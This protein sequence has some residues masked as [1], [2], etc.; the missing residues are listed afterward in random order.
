[1]R[2][3]LGVASLE[4]SRRILL[5][6]AAV[7]VG[8]MPFFVSPFLKLPPV[9]I[10]GM[11]LITA[12]ILVVVA[13]AILGAA[14][15]GGDLGAGRLSFFFSRPLSGASVFTG[16]VLAAILL[17]LLSGLLAAIPVLSMASGP[18]RPTQLLSVSALHVG[19]VLLVL[20]AAHFLG[21]V[22]RARSPWLVLDVAMLTLSAWTL[23]EL[24]HRLNAIGAMLPGDESQKLTA[25]VWA[26][27]SAFFA[28]GLV[29]VVV[30]RTDLARGH[31][32]ASLT[33]WPLFLV[34]PVGLALRLWW[35]E[36]A[37]PRDLTQV[38][39][40]RP[41]PA[42]EWFFLAGPARGGAHSGF[43][44]NTGTGAHQRIGGGLAQPLAF[45][46]EGTRVAWLAYAEEPATPLLVLA[47]L[48]AAPLRETT[49][50]LTP[51]PPT[52][53]HQF[54]LGP[55]A[56]RVLLVER[57][58]SV[59]DAGT[60]GRELFIPSSPGHV[61][62]AAA[63]VDPGRVRS[64]S[65]GP[66]GIEIL[67]ADVPGGRP[68]TRG[69]VDLPLQ[70]DEP[71]QLRGPHLRFDHDGGRMVVLNR[72]P[73]RAAL[74][75]ARVGGDFREL[76]ANPH[77][78]AVDAAF[79]EGGGI[80][81]VETDAQGARL[82]LFTSEA[83]PLGVVEL[84]LAFD[85]VVA[86]AGPNRALVSLRSVPAAVAR[87]AVVDTAALRLTRIEEGL[88]FTDA[89]QVS[90]SRTLL[91]RGPAELVRYDV[92]TGERKVLFRP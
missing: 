10:Q 15:I 63:F 72:R 78:T 76:P 49:V 16:K 38:W 42:G 87:L 9:G 83:R 26:V 59:Y 23:T 27:A 64:Y 24:V 44:V 3:V 74:A 66:D 31:R 88:T 80:A 34:I 6:P 20:G 92:Q 90:G 84:P 52:R 82:R 75:D 14:V 55:G 56:E 7:V 70:L 57:G 43:F 37:T 39:D 32:G 71:F 53:P 67:E 5:L 79:L 30:G 46:E 62:L 21:V 28:A 40:V 17:T 54:V 77:A 1:M 19:M 68:V 48:S 18:L 25:L 47:D 50:V 73:V 65:A 45:N 69:R 60:G 51:P 61:F 8:L 33:F 2:G 29:Q 4:M 91:L 35:L 86:G 89:D 36:G 81:M 11:G 85:P 12:W 41:A 13:A 58:V 22:I